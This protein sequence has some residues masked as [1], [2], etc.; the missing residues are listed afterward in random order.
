VSF[1]ED[2]RRRISI[3]SSLI[4]VTLAGSSVAVAQALAG[5]ARLIQADLDVARAVRFFLE[6][7]NYITGQVLTVDGGL[8][9]RCAVGGEW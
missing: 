7:D 6:P 9:L 1:P 3:W 5:I 4:S 8:T 2:S